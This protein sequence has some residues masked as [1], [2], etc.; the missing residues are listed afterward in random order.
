[1]GG[2]HGAASLSAVPHAPT[3]PTAARAA[4]CLVALVVLTG[5]TGAGAPDAAPTGTTVATP[6]PTPS[7]SLLTDEIAGHTAVGR[8]ADGFPGDLVPVPDGAEVLVSSAVAGPDGT[9][10]ISLNVRTEQ[11][12]AGLLAA[13]RAPLA[14]AG[15]SESAPAAPEAGLA[16]QVTFARSEGAELLVVGVLDRDGVRTL[17]LGGT[18]R[19][20]AP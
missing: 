14:A 13:V 2:S 1:M 17:T 3:S 19:P 6:T 7:E 12:T 8:L 15:F 4:A 10:E 11:D 18:V 9:V 5:C 20:A 16:A